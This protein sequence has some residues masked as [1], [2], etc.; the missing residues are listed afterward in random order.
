M[1]A[2]GGLMGSVSTYRVRALGWY[3]AY[4]EELA[5]LQQRY[6]RADDA[7]VT[8]RQE[9]ITRIFQLRAE[10]RTQRDVAAIVGVS[11]GYVGKIERRFL[12]AI[13][14]HRLRSSGLDAEMP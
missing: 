11:P 13:T 3:L 1:A 7:R 5:S 8:S 4:Q 12:P 10:G 14:R 9:Q 2:K 6:G